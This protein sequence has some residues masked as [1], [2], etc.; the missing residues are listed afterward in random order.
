MEHAG[1]RRR[2]RVRGLA[3]DLDRWAAADRH[4]R[5]TGN[6]G[7]DG[8]VAARRL[9]L[10]GADC[11]RRPRCLGEPAKGAYSARNWDRI[12]RDAG[13]RILHTR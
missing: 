6:N 9:A 12:A 10:A 4:L 1:N 13:I 8:F 7:G 11:R 5:R 3:V 2:G